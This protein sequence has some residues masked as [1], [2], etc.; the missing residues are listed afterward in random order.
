MEP[1]SLKTEARRSG[2]LEELGP[3]EVPYR[4]ML[5]LGEYVLG[6]EEGRSK[7]RGL[8]VEVIRGEEE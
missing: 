1:L 5:E 3:P 7:D 4:V 6:E 8:S 2:L